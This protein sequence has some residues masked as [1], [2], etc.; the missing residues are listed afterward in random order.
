MSTNAFAQGDDGFKSII[1]NVN[2]YIYSVTV[3]EGRSERAYHSPQAERITGYSAEELVADP[4]LWYSMIH[5]KD[6]ERVTDFFKT[7]RSAGKPVAVEHR[8]VCRDGAVRWVVNTCTVIGVAG[9][10]AYRMDGF[11]VDITEQKERELTLRKL[12]R[13][14]EQ[15]PATVVITDSNGVIEYVNPKFT[16]LTGYTLEESVGKNPRILK[17]GSQ[18]AK[19]YRNLWQTILDGKEWRG[20][21]HNRKKNGD[22]YWEFASISP[23]RDGNGDIV[24]F[25]AVKED[26]T[27]RKEAE[28]AL[29][30]SEEKLRERNEAMEK[31]MRLAQLTQRALLY[32]ELPVFPRCAIEHRYIPLDN[33]GGDYFTVLPYG[34]HEMGVFIGDVSGHGVAAA[35]FVALVKFTT[36]RIFRKHA[37]APAEYIKRLN[38]QLKDYMSSY[39]LTGIYGLFS[40]RDDGTA[41]L[42]F[43]NG[44]H[45]YPMLVRADGSA[46]LF[47]SRGTIIGAFEQA[48]YE[49]KTVQLAKGDRVFFYTDGI[50]ETENECKEMIGFE[51]DLLELFRRSKRAT[52]GETLDEVIEAVNRFRGTARID[53]DIVLLGFEVL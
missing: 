30:V 43:C 23:I 45:P 11:L 5:E 7:I 12:S 2:E 21:F 33:V 27:A 24:N 10:D 1:D 50:P 36:D 17:S 9:S 20:E 13:A 52:L 38:I 48:V 3:R 37:F 46:E 31:D 6:R 29:R 35:L 28:Q 49:E 14:I 22:L 32:K 51:G 16:E 19:F 44:G 34:D 39:F 25:I 18:D 41:Q 47:D 53:D 15:S 26:V 4:N 40:F 42:T 8:I